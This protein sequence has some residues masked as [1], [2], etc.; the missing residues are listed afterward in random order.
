MAQSVFSLGYRKDDEGAGVLFPAGIINSYLDSGQE[1][2]GAQF[3][4]QGVPVTL[5]PVL[6][7]PR[8]QPDH[9]PTSDAQV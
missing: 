1:G 8:I 4:I 2:S 6:R 7:R 9:S 5:S 3:A